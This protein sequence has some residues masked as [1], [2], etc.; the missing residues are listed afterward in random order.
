MGFVHLHVH[1]EYS[2]LDGACRIHELVARTAEL[3]QTAVAVTDHGVMYGVIDFYKEAKKAG[4]KPIIGCEVYVAARSRFDKIHELDSDH[5]HLVLLCENEKGYRNLIKLISAAWIEGFYSRPRVDHELLEQYHEGLIALSACLAGEIPRSLMRGDY[6]GA[7]QIA[8]R[9]DNLFG[10]NNYYLELQDHGLDEQRTINPQLIKLSRETGIPLVCTNDAHYLTKEDSRIQRV[11]ICIQTNTTINEPSK[12]SFE[13]DE[14]YLKSEQEMRSLF[15]EIPEAFDNTQKIADRCNLEFEFGNTKLP[16][17][18]APGGDSVKYF[19]R[20]CREGM[21]RIYGKNPSS[22][23]VQRLEYE[24]ETIERMGYV[25]YYLIVNDFVQYAKSHDIPVGPGRGSGAASL[26][27]YC[28]GITGIDPI[29]YNLLFERFLNPERV[30]MPDFDIDFCN[31]KRQLVIDYV[32]EKYGSDHVAQIVTFG[33]MAARAAIRDVAR[34]MGLPYA[35]ADRTAKLVPWEL[36]MTLEKAINQSKP[37]SELYESDPQVR[38]LLDMAKKVEGMPRH[39]STHAA[40]VVITDKPVSDYVPLCMNGELIATQYP[41]NILEELGLLKMDFLGLRNLTVIDDAQ[42]MIRK[43]IPGFDIKK[44]SLDDQEVYTMMS[45]G[46]TEGVFQFESAGMKRVL[47]GLGPDCFED[48][49]AVIALYRPGPMDSIPKYINNHHHL[50][51]I[52]YAHPLLKSILEVTNGCIVYQEQVMQIFRELAGYS[53]GRADIV[54]RAMSRKK[55][56]VMERERQIFIKGFINENG[57][58]E[59]DGCVRRG[60]SEKVA[61]KVFNEM[62][63]FASYAFNKAHAAAYALVSYQTAYLKCHYPKEYFA[64]LLTSILDGSGKVAGY[65]AE[66]ERLGIKVLPPSVNESRANFTVSG[67]GIRFGLLAVKNLGKGLI[68]ELVR[69]R[70]E[71]G[72]Y[73]SFYSFCRRISVKRE[74]NSR[75]LESLIQCGALDKL[76]VNRRQMLQ[77]MESILSQ[78]DEQNRRNLAG[79]IGLFD[80]LGEEENPEPKLPDLPEFSYN[81]ILAMEKE[82]TGLYISGHPLTPYSKLYNNSHIDRIDRILSSAEDDTGDYKDSDNVTLFGM[83]DSV[84]QKSTRSN[85]I[86]AYATIEDLYGS[87]ELLVFPRVLTRYSSLLKPGEV[88]LAR[89]RISIKEEEEPKL[90]VDSIE[91][92]P[93]PEE[94]NSKAKS[95]KKSHKKTPTGLYLRVTSAN[96]EDYKRACLVTSVFDG[97]APMYIR[98]NDTGKLMRAPKSMAVWPNQIMLDEL[99]RI[100]GEENVVFIN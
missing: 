40:G 10:R 9:Y 46:N 4:I 76:G 74:F 26:C 32:I 90:L 94:L 100:L 30:S 65:I 3:G 68:T 99:K 64:A 69:E 98:F 73:S 43:N 35:T 41:M 29:K 13:T 50:D 31:E 18:N 49:I 12:M 28:I 52:L 57:V 48:L 92:P 1:S 22:D 25:D 36:G 19:R 33:T 54:R 81:D 80:A 27:A 87:I 11:L 38:G 20:Q 97:G 45:Q 96:G 8:V 77:S 7:R 39:A 79:Q 60:V 89:G 23:V 61:E 95:G 78:L 37:L 2:L 86:M 66:C 72:S 51:Q 53:L 71:G 93:Q 56:D 44:I 6:D 14:F 5:A 58:V 83:I 70:E 17:F 75:S 15:P 47:I 85:S 34:A 84:R 59:V 55:H 21:H 88:V 16:S 42:K 63:S 91:P 62:S 24:M 82:V 67:D